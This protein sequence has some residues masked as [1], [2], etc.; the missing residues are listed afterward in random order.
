MIL[1]YT[2]LIKMEGSYLNYS[3]NKYDTILIDAFKGLN[4]PFEL[5]TYEALSHAEGYTKTKWDSA[6]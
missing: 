6:Y 1:V 3:K 4:A 5:T 2:C